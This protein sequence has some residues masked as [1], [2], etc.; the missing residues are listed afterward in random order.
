MTQYLDKMNVE[1]RNYTDL[2]PFLRKREWGEGK[3]SFVISLSQSLSCAM[4]DDANEIGLWLF[5]CI[6]DYTAGDVVCDIVDVDAF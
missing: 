6:V 1:R 5:F 3:V 4:D 2:W